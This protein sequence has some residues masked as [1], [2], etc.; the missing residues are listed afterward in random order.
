ML[1]ENH[2]VIAAYILR[3]LTFGLSKIFHRIRKVSYDS[4]HHLNSKQD[5]DLSNGIQF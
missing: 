1:I 2:F 3:Q 5:L 4:A